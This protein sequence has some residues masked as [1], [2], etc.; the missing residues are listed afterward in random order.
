MANHKY[1]KTRNTRGGCHLCKPHKVAGNARSAIKP[2][3]RAKI[4]FG[5][6]DAEIDIKNEDLIGVDN[7]IQ[8]MVHEKG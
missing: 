4:T 7:D 2:K 8:A 3:Y 6:L 1:K 5:F